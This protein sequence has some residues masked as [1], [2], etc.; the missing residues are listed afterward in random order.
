LEECPAAVPVNQGS[1]NVGI[2]LNII[3]EPISANG[4]PPLCRIDQFR[5]CRFFK[6]IG[7]LGYDSVHASKTK[8]IVGMSVYI[9][10]AWWLIGA[11]WQEVWVRPIEIGTQANVGAV[12]W[13]ML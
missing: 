5:R 8:K 9:A 12:A 2:G 13:I 3:V 11:A 10:G 1:E 6:P 7:D 4:L